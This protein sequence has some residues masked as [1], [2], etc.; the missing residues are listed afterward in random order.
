[1]SL[2]YIISVFC[3]LFLFSAAF[4]ADTKSSENV[5]EKA[6]L[7]LN[8]SLKYSRLCN[9]YDFYGL[10]K[11]VKWIAYFE[12]KGDD[13]TKPPFLHYQW[14]EFDG[15]GGVKSISS[16][17]KLKQDEVRK[18]L[19]EMGFD[20]KTAFLSKGFMTVKYISDDKQVR[21]S[22]ER[23]RCSIAEK[24]MKVPALNVEIKKGD[25]LMTLLAK[26]NTI[27]YFRLLRRIED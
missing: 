25:I 12:L 22:E 11:V 27:I 5:T 23:W 20:A 3:F 26:D 21:A 13:W 6:A 10:W 24:D 19:F 4:S 7:E 14:F 18:K 9:E 16:S 17:R 2:K 8:T 15:K 1:M